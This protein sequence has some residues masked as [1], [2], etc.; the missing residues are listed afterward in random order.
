MADRFVQAGGSSGRRDH[1]VACRGRHSGA[2]SSSSA[3]SRCARRL[4]EAGC[5]AP[6]RARPGG[7][8]RVRLEGARL[9]V[10]PRCG[11]DSG[12]HDEGEA[13][14]RRSGRVGI[15]PAGC[16]ARCAEAGLAIDDARSSPSRPLARGSRFLGQPTAPHGVVTTASVG[17]AR[18]RVGG[19]TSRRRAWP[20]WRGQSRARFARRRAGSAHIGGGR[21]ADPS[22]AI[23]DRHHRAAVVGHAR[24]WDDPAAHH[25]GARRALVDQGQV[26]ALGAGAM[27]RKRAAT[28]S[29][30]S[31]AMAYARPTERGPAEGRPRRKRLRAAPCCDDQWRSTR[32]TDEANTQ[33]LHELDQEA[34]GSTTSPAACSPAGR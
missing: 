21:V 30:S 7:R 8:K 5:R 20:R 19:G 31:L 9:G 15:D 26:Q 24:R 10:E 14:P 18:G 34:C 2:A 13:L 4:E 16:R 3:A 6:P 1:Q 33:Q 22:A 29:R 17:P 28:A 11:R 32:R 27:A 12:R 25:Q 23:P